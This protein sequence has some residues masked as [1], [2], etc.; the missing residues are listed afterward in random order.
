MNVL[1][2]RSFSYC[3][4]GVRN[5]VECG[6]TQGMGAGRMRGRAREGLWDG[7]MHAITFL[8]NENDILRKCL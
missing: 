5:G 4:R 7:G 6:G 3:E 1:K 2:K 8:K